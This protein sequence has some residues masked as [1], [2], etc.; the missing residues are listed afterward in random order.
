MT[1][2]WGYGSR[3]KIICSGAHWEG[4]NQERTQGMVEYELGLE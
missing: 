3:E 4:D 2:G 1:S